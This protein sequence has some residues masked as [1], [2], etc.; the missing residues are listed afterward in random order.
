MKRADIL[1]YWKSHR[2]NI[3]CLQDIHIDPDRQDELRNEWGYEAIICAFRSNARGVAILFN[4]NFEFTIKG[5]SEHAD[6][7]YIVVDLT[8]QE[9]DFTIINIYG[10][11][12]DSPELY[13]ELASVLE[14]KEDRLT[15]ACGDWNIALSPNLDT[16]HYLHENNPRSRAVLT[17]LMT[18]LDLVD[19]WRTLNKDKREYTWRQSDHYLS[20]AARLDYFIISKALLNLVSDT[21]IIPGYR[22]DH[23]AI[24]ISL[25][26]GP[27]KRG[28]GYWK[29]NVSLLKDPEYI[30]IVKDTIR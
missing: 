28:K 3:L 8:I 11:N 10:P 29:F 30:D 1:D 21:Q 25:K 4:N 7:H 22:T 27:G 6:C 23:S 19:I 20:K 13:T 18:D 12:K 24:K 16:V 2:P 14:N 15:I 26:L 17:N 9:L 5:F